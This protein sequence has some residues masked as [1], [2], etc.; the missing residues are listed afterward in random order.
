[1]ALSYPTTA[2]RAPPC[3]AQVPG[4]H[5]SPQGCQSLPQQC[6][7]SAGLQPPQSCPTWPWAP[8]S[9]P[10]SWPNLSPSPRRCPGPGAG[11][12]QLPCSWLNCYG[13][14]LLAH[15]PLDWPLGHSD[16]TFSFLCCSGRKYNLKDKHCQMTVERDTAML[17]ITQKV[18][19]SL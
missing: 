10:M 19:T 14:S 3:P 7:R 17:Q 8:P 13:A 6:C 18:M 11:P 15:H 2:P 5:C 9:W 12:P 16:H 4:P 1:M